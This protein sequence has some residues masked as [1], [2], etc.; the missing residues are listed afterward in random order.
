MI[1]K[2]IRCTACNQII[3]NYEGSE[4][5]RSKSLPGVEWSNADL[6]TAKKFLRL[7]SGH[8]LEELLVEENSCVSQKPFH[9]PVRESHFLAS[10]AD[11]K[12]LIRRT[13]AALDQPAFYEILPGRLKVSNA[14]L[15]IQEKDLRKQI[16]VEEG[17][18][19]LLKEKMERFIQVFRDEVTGISPEKVEEETKDIEEGECSTLAYMGLTDSCWTRI[20]GRCRLY[21]DESEL[22]ALGRFVDENRNPPDVLSI[23]VERQISIISPAE[24]ETGLDL[25][26]KRE[27]EEDIEAPPMAISKRGL[28]RGS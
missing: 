14:S 27:T 13:K 8:R 2:L 5:I 12:F 16:A 11:R 24:A 15:K 9:E 19:P 4:L 26:E 17:F 21:F 25:Q 18:S 7:H 22:Q 10:N 20:L 6:T 1:K 23:L 3:P 28:R